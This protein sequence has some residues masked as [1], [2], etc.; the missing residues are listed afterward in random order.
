MY[1]P[2]PKRYGKTLPPV[3]NPDGRV[4][5][6]IQVPDELEYRAA[7]NGA[8]GSL[9]E[10]F[11][12]EHYQTDYTDPPARN[13]EAAQVWIDVLA[14]AVWEECMDICSQIIDCIVNNPDTQAAIREFILNDPAINQKMTQI[15]QAE[16]LSIE[17]RLQ[18][19]LKPEQCEPDFVFNQ[20]SVLVQ[21]VHDVSEDIF[22]ALE[23]ASNQL[24]R[25]DIF[26]GAIP[27]A[28]VND[29]AAT[30]FRVADQIAEEIAEDY[31]GA[32]DE[33]LYD[34][35]RCKIFC[36]CKDDCT[37]SIDKAIS[38]YTELLGDEVPDN[39]LDAF[40]AILSFI[41]N[42]DFGTDV[43]VYLMHLLVL[44]AIRLTQ[45]VFGIDFGVLSNR[46]LAAG[47]DPDNDW[48]ILCDE[49]PPEPT[50]N[51]MYPWFTAYNNG[52]TL[53]SQTTEYMI[54]KSIHG[55]LYSVEF[56]D[57]SRNHFCDFVRYEI[58][59]G[60]FTPAGPYP[61]GFVS[62][63]TGYV[64]ETDIDRENY[65]VCLMSYLSSTDFT[66]KLYLN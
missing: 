12:W 42:G 30:V 66:I 65:P 17:Q 54:I 58:V 8:I 34:K 39:P 18:N 15:A 22:E 6:T 33:A 28:G 64:N 40:L 10:W 44:T 50:E 23:V 16:A 61:E 5:F 47:D 31:S 52:C 32:Y 13:K 7:L 46:I 27:A 11:T 26:V 43:P 57:T 3:I 48:E 19:L 2:L 55:G 35:I 20:C 38:V 14:D 29:T 4:C 9:G 21:L 51:C 1:T 59:S 41:S 25:A 56:G 37:L 63:T 62:W 24:E 36:A 60:T 45:N 53:L 49:C